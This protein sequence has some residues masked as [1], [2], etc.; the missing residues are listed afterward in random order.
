MA[1]EMKAG[2]TAIQNT[3]VKLSASAAM[4]R[5]ASSGPS[6]A[7]MVSSDWRRPKAVPRRSAGVRSATRASRGAPRMPLP[8][9]S[10]KRAAVSQPM[11][12]AKGKIGFDSAARP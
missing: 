10:M 11:P 6:T 5:M 9:R 4:N 2:M 12:V 1:A 3:Y 7:P 8:T